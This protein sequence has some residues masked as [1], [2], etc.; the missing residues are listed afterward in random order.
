MRIPTLFRHCSL[1]T[2]G[3]DYSVG[4]LQMYLVLNSLLTCRGWRWNHCVLFNHN[5]FSSP[6][7]AFSSFSCHLDTRVVVSHPQSAI[8]K[9]IVSQPLALTWLISQLALGPDGQLPDA[10]EFEW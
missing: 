8:W 9:A 5:V 3:L 6:L 10:T 7:C 1:L 4:L 2:T